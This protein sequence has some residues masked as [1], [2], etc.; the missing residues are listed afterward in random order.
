MRV[1]YTY[2]MDQPTTSTVFRPKTSPRDFFLHL[3]ATGALYFCAV[4]VIMLLRQYVDYFFPDPLAY[5]LFGSTSDAMRFS[6]A[7][8]VVLF[9]AY[10]I[11][12]WFLGREVDRD[13]SKQDI[14][15][16]RWS[17][18]LTLFIS[19]VTIVGDLVYLVY[20]F[21]G[22]DFTVRFILQ[23]V[24]IL[25]VAAAVF[26]YYMF[27]LRRA[28]GSHQP[29]RK[30]ITVGSLVIIGA[31]IVGAF[32]IIGSPAQNRA[33]AWDAQR[34][35]DLESLQYQIVTFWQQ[36]EK[37]PKDL[38]ELSDPL[39]GYGIPNDPE[40]KAAYEYRTTG[41]RSFELCATFGTAFD[42]TKDKRIIPPTGPYPPS[43]GGDNWQHS[44]GHQCFSRTIDP[45]RYPPFSKTPTE[46]I[47]IL[48][49]ESL[50][51]P[52]QVRVD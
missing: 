7:L 28:P 42:P 32:F 43:E 29:T 25:V 11:V 45:Q 39:S 22:G 2:S 21:L 41:D 50:P 44:E 47:P 15:V 20:S 26:A 17:L 38:A 33:Q 49:P 36:K 5:S 16:R 37:L 34:V 46:P 13:P 18:Y 51:P 24:A 48:A 23:A 1:V 10:V 40:T 30:A 3:F 14:W 12:M 19:G 31:L 35:S 6:I 27:L 4:Y 52:T 8:L 9:P